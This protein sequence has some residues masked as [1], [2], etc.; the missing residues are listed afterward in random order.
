M[1]PVKRGRDPPEYDSNQGY[2]GDHIRSLRHL[3]RERRDP[4]IYIGIDIAK[5]SHFVFVIS[6]NSKMLIEPFEFTNN[7]EGFRDLSLNRYE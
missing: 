5:S 7:A 1:L 6:C 4:I 2:D 3:T